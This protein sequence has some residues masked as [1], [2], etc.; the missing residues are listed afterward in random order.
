MVVCAYTHTH[1]Q[2]L[3]ELC[4]LERVT[5]VAAINR[6]TSTAFA[7]VDRVVMLV[8][9]RSVYCGA[10]GQPALAFLQSM[11]QRARDPGMMMLLLCFGGVLVVVGGI[12]VVVGSVD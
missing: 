8:E 5:V 10:A 9:G 3:R 6:P 12:L 11:V 1:T 7:T 4:K 2:T